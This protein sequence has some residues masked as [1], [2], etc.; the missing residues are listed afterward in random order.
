MYLVKT[1]QFI[2]SLFPNFVWKVPSKDKSIYLTF[3]DGPVPE[4]T[5]WVLE[6]LKDFNAKATFFCV[7]ENVKKNPDIFSSI[8]EDGHT[9]GSH[10]F[11]HLNG[12]STENIKY[13]H[14]VRMGAY[15]V[16]SELFRPPYGRLMPRQAMFLQRHY[17][18]VMWDVL[19]GDFDPNI[20]QE[21]CLNNVVENVSPGSIVVFHDNI[22]AKGNLDFTLP[23]VLEHF[24]SEGYTFKAIDAENLEFKQHL[25]PSA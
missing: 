21:R 5:P 23:R 17:N 9:V 20:S 10:T 15:E 14:N 2:Q 4:V 22:K 18:I 1:P 13:F 24:S 16:K 8:I 11:N 12:W 3:D 7:G 6:T 19:S 25:R